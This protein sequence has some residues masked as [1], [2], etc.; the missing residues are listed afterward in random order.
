MAVKGWDA[1]EAKEFVARRELQ[2]QPTKQFYRWMQS[3]IGDRILVDKTPSYA[4]DLEILKRAETNFAQPRYIHLVRHPG[5]MIHSFE[6]ARLEQVFF[7]YAHSFSR[8]ELAELIWLISHQNIL[9][10]LNEIPQ[11]RQC[12]IQ[13]EDLLAQPAT[14][15]EK[16]CRLIGCE[17]EPEM[18]RIHENPQERMTDGIHPLSRMLGDVKFHTHNGIDA[19]VAHSWK[20]HFSADFLSDTTQELAKSLGYS[21]FASPEPPKTPA[22][23]RTLMPIIPGSAHLAAKGTQTGRSPAAKPPFFCV[24]GAG[25]YPIYFYGLAHCLGLEQ[26]FYGLQTPSLDGK[27]KPYD[28]V[29]TMAADYIQALQAVQ[30]QG[31]YFIGGHSAGSRVALEMVRQ[32]DQQEQQIALLA[33]IDSAAPVATKSEDNLDFLVDDTAWLILLAHNIEQMTSQSLEMSYEMLQP[34]GWEQQL[35]HFKHQ[36]EKINLKWLS[37]DAGITQLHGLWQTFKANC[38]INQTYCPPIAALPVKIALFATETDRSD[39]P[40]EDEPAILQQMR[41]QTSPKK[42]IQK[43]SEDPT[44]GWQQFSTYPVEIYPVPGNHFTVTNPPHVQVLAEKLKNCLIQAQKN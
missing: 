31:P 37:A 7:R 20:K 15:L 28:C 14:A 11:A 6:A 30:S 9:S 44:R 16:A 38:Q 35:K 40:Q 10:F 25:G 19:A 24:P 33:I 43:F 29:E 13:F 34:L 18:L 3:E 41:S 5:G 22:L 1:R 39:C 8:R 36:L 21:D 17:F 42:R 23:P 27:S 26:P 2:Q 32:L 12:R 4:L